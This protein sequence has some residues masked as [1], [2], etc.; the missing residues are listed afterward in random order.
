MFLFNINASEVQGEDIVH[1]T[2]FLRELQRLLNKGLMC[3][4]VS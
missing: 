2:F 3:C 4:V 1:N